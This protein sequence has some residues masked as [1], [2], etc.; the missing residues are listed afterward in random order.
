MI[1]IFFVQRNIIRYVFAELWVNACRRRVQVSSDA[2]LSG[3][4]YAMEIDETVIMEDLGVIRG[5]A[6][7]PAHV[8]G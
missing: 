3:C 6:A 1:R 7:R 4:F 2:I 8:C 5:A